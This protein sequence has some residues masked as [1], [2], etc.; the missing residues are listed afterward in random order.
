MDADEAERSG[1]VSRVVAADRLVDDAVETAQKIAGMSLPV[2]LMVKEAVNRSYEMSL[3]EGVRF[4]RRLFPGDL[5]H[6]RP[7]RGH[8]GVRGEAKAELHGQVRIG[9]T[10]AASRRSAASPPLAPISVNPTGPSR[11]RGRAW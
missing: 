2:A 9:S 4:E 10:P 8:G 11:A 3:S 7:E 6:R 1:L 5:R